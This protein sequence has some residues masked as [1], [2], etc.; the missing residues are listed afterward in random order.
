M[1]IGNETVRKVLSAS[2][3]TGQI[4]LNKP[5]ANSGSTLS[6]SK[7]TQILGSADLC[8]NCAA[9]QQT[10]VVGT[11]NQLFTLNSFPILDS[12][13]SAG[14][15]NLANRFFNN[16]DT[17]VNPFDVSLVTVTG[18]AVATTIVQAVTASNGLV[19][20]SN[21]VSNTTFYVMHWGS[22]ANRTG[23]AV[24]VASQADPTGI[25]VTLNESG[26]TTG[27]FRTNILAI[28]SASEASANPPQ[29]KVALNDVIPLRPSIRVQEPYL[30]PT[31]TMPK[32]FSTQRLSLWTTTADLSQACSR[33]R[34]AQ[35]TLW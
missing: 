28:S 13:G 12:G 31:C 25:T 8:P 30:A 17:V 22:K 7:V 16:G 21:T 29:L 9:A 6:I 3:T 34:L 1:L 18:T 27:I 19:N 15:M 32:E 14:P 26:P 20:I 24:T 2:N 33:R 23:A 5:M 4:V 11:G 10:T 35:E